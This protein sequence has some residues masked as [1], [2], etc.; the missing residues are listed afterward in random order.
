MLLIHEGLA[1]L[2]FLKPA[3]VE[4]QAEGVFDRGHLHLLQE[5]NVL[6]QLA[7]EH[8]VSR[9]HVDPSRE[10]AVN[11]WQ[12]PI[13]LFIFDLLEDLTDIMEALA[14]LLLDGDLVEHELATHQLLC[15]RLRVV[16][17]E[18][19]DN[20]TDD[21]LSLVLERVP[22]ADAAE[23][24]PH[25]LAQS[26]IAE[27]ELVLREAILEHFSKLRAP[28]DDE[29]ARWSF[30]R[31]EEALHD[32]RVGT[33]DGLL[34]HE[35]DAKDD[36]LAFC[37]DST[38]KQDV[39]VEARSLQPLVDEDKVVISLVVGLHLGRLI[40]QIC[41]LVARVLLEENGEAVLLAR[42]LKG[43]PHLVQF[44]EQLLE[45]EDERRVRWQLLRG[46][47]HA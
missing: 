14:V 21:A 13:L 41:R 24:V 16:H 17:C 43:L 35:A 25:R 10:L 34:P 18:Q 29:A 8:V 36:G 19:V 7:P 46:R 15:D 42:L 3:E 39:S 30:Y 33:H 32:V 6:G 37:I 12:R 38:E 2:A 45:V 44:G 28:L 40:K 4:H 26:A 47:L 5:L 11:L 31:R 9:L 1:L 23:L 20:A 22:M 27:I